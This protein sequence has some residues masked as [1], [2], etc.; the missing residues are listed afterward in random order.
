M[1]SDKIFYIS[2][3]KH[4]SSLLHIFHSPTHKNK[5]KKCPKKRRKT[6]MKFTK[7]FQR[8]RELRGKRATG[9]HDHKL[10]SSSS[11]EFLKCCQPGD[12]SKKPQKII[13][14]LTIFLISFL[15]FS[16]RSTMK[17]HP[18]SVVHLSDNPLDS[19]KVNILILFP[20]QLTLIST[21]LEISRI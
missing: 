10:S 5:S 20:L 1:R 4:K 13:L 11:C 15:F 8:Q 12:D 17:T 7:A 9:C 16:F 3:L 19:N 6:E 2:L 14:N 18:G 21:I